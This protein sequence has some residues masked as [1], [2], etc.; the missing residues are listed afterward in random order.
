MR[1]LDQRARSLRVAQHGQIDRAVLGDH[2]LHV[3][4]R[5]GDARAFAERG[6]DGRHAGAPTFAVDLR[7]RKLCPSGAAAAPLTKDSWPP[8]PEYCRPPS[9][10]AATCPAR[11]IDSAPLMLVRRGSI[12]S[13]DVSFTS[14]TGRMRT[15]GLP[16]SQR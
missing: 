5:R 7:Q 4:A 6:D 10:S 13:T 11:S 15:D 14:V 16:S 8:V 9:E 1:E 12:C 3:M 2:P